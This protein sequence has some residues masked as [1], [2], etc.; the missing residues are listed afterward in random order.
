MNIYSIKKNGKAI[1]YFEDGKIKFEGEYLNNS[2]WNGK[3]YN[4]NG[5]L[6]YEIKNGKKMRKKMI[7]M[8]KPW[9]TPKQKKFHQIYR[10]YFAFLKKEMKMKKIICLNC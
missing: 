6:I 7:M 8:K 2:K 5:D 9:N 4:T 10:C 1:K 3:G